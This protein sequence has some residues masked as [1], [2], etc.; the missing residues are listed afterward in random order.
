LLVGF[1]FSPFSSKE[2]EGTRKAAKTEIE[3]TPS[4]I[5]FFYYET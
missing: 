3:I 4:A 5:I 1:S 2:R